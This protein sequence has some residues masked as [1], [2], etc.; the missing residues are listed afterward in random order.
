MSE[1]DD[2]LLLEYRLSRITGCNDR[3]LDSVH[4]IFPGVY[5]ENKA[6]INLCPNN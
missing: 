1:S 3:I 6:K 4:L 2:L 5:R